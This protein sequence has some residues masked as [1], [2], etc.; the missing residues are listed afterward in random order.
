VSPPPAAPVAFG[1]RATRRV[2]ALLLRMEYRRVE[3][4]GAERVPLSGPLLLVP[5]HHN[6]LVDSMAIL[7]TSPRPAGPM[8]KAP[9]WKSRLLRPFLDAVEAIPIYRPQDAEENEGRGARANLETFAECIRRLR[10]GRSLVLFPEGVSRPS[11][12]L[13]PLRTGAARIALDSGVAVAVVPVGLQY[14]PPASRR[15]TLLVRFGEPFVVDGRESPESRRGRVVE[16]TRRMERSMR[17]LLVEADSLEDAELLRVGAAVLSQETS[18]DDEALERRHA[19]LRRLAEGFE[20]L[21]R[22]DPAER[23][24]LR[25]EA[26]SFARE[27]TLLGIPLELLDARYGAARVLRFVARTLAV[28]VLGLPMALVASVATAPAR[29]FGDLVA[30]RGGEVTEDVLP[31]ARILGRAFFLVVETVLVAVLLGV[32]V[33]PLVGAAVLAVL[34]ALYAVHVVWTDWRADVARRGRAFFLLAGGRLRTRLRA[35]RRTLAARIE[36][37]GATVLSGS[38]D[39]SGPASPPPA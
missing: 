17:A 7:A 34:P 30:L 33:S 12:R 37:A 8:A 14:E 19:L 2:A 31:F 36:R 39:P 29:W 9:L 28:V 4:F 23:A 18:A 32:F 26:S 27:L 11:A 35:R 20:A 21:R 5:N 15:G 25:A 16:A 13:L 6:S 24:A 22:V 38:G 10:A 3:T 1:Y